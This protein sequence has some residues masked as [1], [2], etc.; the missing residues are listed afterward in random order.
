MAGNSLGGY[1]A[2]GLAARGRA[3][4]VVAFAPAGGWPD[5]AFEQ[6]L[7]EHFGPL[8]ALARAA[9]PQADAIMATAEGRRRAT[10]FTTVAW[11]HIP[12]DLLTHQL[13]GVAA[14]VDVGPMQEAALREGWPLDAERIDRPVRIVWG[15]EDRILPWPQAATRHRERLPNADWVVLDGVGH[16]PQLDVPRECAELILGSTARVS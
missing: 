13:L 2:L 6:E 15:A 4:S 10:Q 11:E 9:A 14:C 3:E 5:E 7:H 12:A 8:Q 1:L 16:C